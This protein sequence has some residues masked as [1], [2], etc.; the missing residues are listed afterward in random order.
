[1]YIDAYIYVNCVESHKALSKP[2]NPHFSPQLPPPALVQPSGENPVWD[3]GE[4]GER[5][6]PAFETHCE[7]AS[8]GNTF[9][10]EAG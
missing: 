1:M 2:G 7:E 9:L 6:V 3:V 10:K 8:Q 4:V 5:C